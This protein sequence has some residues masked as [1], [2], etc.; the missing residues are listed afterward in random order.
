MALK[1]RGAGKDNTGNT[2]CAQ[3][4]IALVTIKQCKDYDK[5]RPG[6]VTYRSAILWNSCLETPPGEKYQYTWLKALI[7][8]KCYKE[9]RFITLDRQEKI[10]ELTNLIH[11][12]VRVRLCI[13]NY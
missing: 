9:A 11:N 8:C 2:R 13:T 12:T 5:P 7:A 1:A 3:T 4:L 10:N 6:N